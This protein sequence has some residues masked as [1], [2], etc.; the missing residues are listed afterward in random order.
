[1]NDM[2]YV[3]KVVGFLLFADTALIPGNDVENLKTTPQITDLRTTLDQ[4]S[5]HYTSKTPLPVFSKWDVLVAKE[6]HVLRELNIKN[7][8]P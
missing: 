7:N 6:V 2:Y 5:I 4:K 8:L 3:S 1:M